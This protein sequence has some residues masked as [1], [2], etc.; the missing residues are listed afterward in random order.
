MLILSR[1]YFSSLGGMI[2][3]G[4]VLVFASRPDW[5]SGQQERPA[6]LLKADEIFAP[7]R[8][9]DIAIEIKDEDW[10]ALCNQTRDFLGALGG[11]ADEKVFTYFPANVT[12]DGKKVQNVGI[13]KKGF[14]G[15][16]DA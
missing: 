9:V 5:A 4:L 3:F 12:I 7:G 11:S 10:L 15:S 1:C 6:E 16:L 8:I 13:R 14:L 2:L